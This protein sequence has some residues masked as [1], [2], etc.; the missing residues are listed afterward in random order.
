MR[1]IL[2]VIALYGYWLLLSGHYYVWL[3]ALGGALSLA[4]VLF[5]SVKNIADDEG[6][7]IGLVPRGMIYWP[8]LIW[9]ILLSGLR[10]SRLILA[11]SLPISPTMVRVDTDSETAV[12]L[13]TYANSITLTPGTL[14]VEVS[15]RRRAI[16]VHA[17]ERSGAEGFADDPM[18]HKVAWMERG[19]A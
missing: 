18:N 8:W 11:P 16:W 10:V 12:G 15:Q 6:F 13:A 4:I 17:I 7:P 1:Y 2:I 9:Q 14:S 5:C 3:M 19:G